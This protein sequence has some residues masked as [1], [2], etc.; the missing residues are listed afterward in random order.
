MSKIRSLLVGAGMGDE[1]AKDVR[2]ALSR[3]VGFGE[4]GDVKDIMR[5]AF[6]SSENFDQKMDKLLLLMRDATAERA[7]ERDADDDK[8]AEAREARERAEKLAR[9]PAEEMVITKVV[10]ACI[11][12]SGQSELT[13]ALGLEKSGEEDK[14]GELV[15]KAAEVATLR[16]TEALLAGSKLPTG[17]KPSD[18]MIAL[19]VRGE[20]QQPRTIRAF[21]TRRACT[22]FGARKNIK[23]RTALQTDL[24]RLMGEQEYDATVES[25][26]GGPLRA[27]HLILLDALARGTAGATYEDA[28]DDAKDG[29]GG[30]V[31]A[32]GDKKVR[33]AGGRRIM[34][35]VLEHVV[36]YGAGKSEGEL[37]DLYASS[38]EESARIMNE[39]EGAA[40]GPSIAQGLKDTR[41]LW[42]GGKQAGDKRKLPGEETPGGGGGGRLT[43]ADVCKAYNNP[44]GCRGGCGKQHV[45]NWGQ[46]G[47]GGQPCGSKKHN[48]QTGHPRPLKKSEAENQTANQTAQQLTAA[49]FAP[50]PAQAPA[51]APAEAGGGGGRQNQA[52]VDAFTGRRG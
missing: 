42:A 27:V 13:K 2:K 12:L 23:L 39:S 28:E 21:D 11:E 15:V 46:G 17:L 47:M 1:L 9:A 30:F 19:H 52:R 38:I 29:L 51:G 37:L 25:G 49:A 50:S 41:A 35:T 43:Q 14:D 4:P 3:K 26:G 8:K 24:E 36:T 20:K 45:C 34:L 22:E 18:K 16:E 31:Q 44:S 32:L 10:R 48:R 33:T 40:P 5:G 6:N 7:K